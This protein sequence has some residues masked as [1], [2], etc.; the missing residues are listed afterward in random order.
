MAVIGAAVVPPTLVSEVYDVLGVEM[1]INAYGLTETTG[2]CT[3]ARRGD[4]VEVVAETCGRPIDGVRV[5]TVDPDGEVL[6][7]GQAGEVEV[8]GSNVMVGYLDDPEATAEALHDGWLR[9]G[10]VGV[11][12]DAGN[13]RIVDRLKDMLVVGGFN[14]YPAE[15]ERVLGEHPAVDQVAVVGQPDQRMGEVPVA[16]VVPAKGPGA[17]LDGDEAPRLRRRTTGRV[18]GPPP[19]HRCGHLAVERRREGG[20]GNTARPAVSP[21]TRPVSWRGGIGAGCGRRP[22]GRRRAPPVPRWPPAR[23]PRTAGR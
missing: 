20:Q 14:A 5:R 15:I 23:G 4:P 13:L 2:V 18:Q 3:M 16:F 8:A 1:V 22:P 7:V 19:L 12:D 17:S 21:P 6:A 10:D 9:T 11:I